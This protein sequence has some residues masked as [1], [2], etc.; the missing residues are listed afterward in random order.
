MSNLARES[1][2]KVSY[3]KLYRV[4]RGVEIRYELLKPSS[5]LDWKDVPR[6]KKRMVL[7]FIRS[8]YMGVS[9]RD[10]VRGVYSVLLEDGYL[11]GV[12]YLMDSPAASLRG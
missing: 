11:V 3:D 5:V 4:K 7:N 6:S 9:V 1:S 8:Y 10:V 12:S 2:K